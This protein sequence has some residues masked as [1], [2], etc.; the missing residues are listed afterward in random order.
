M[1]VNYE[2]ALAALR[3]RHGDK[4][5]AHSVGTAQA[6]EQL[7]LIYGVD[8]ADARLAGLLHDWDRELDGAAVTKAAEVSGV[9][10]GDAERVSPKLL[11]ART[12]ARAVLEAFPELPA[13]V[14]SAIEKHTLA[15]L[16][17]SPLDQVVYIADMMEPGRQYKGVDA[18]REAA[19]TVSLDELFALAYQQSMLHVVRS[20]KHMHPESVA[21]WNAAVARRHG[22]S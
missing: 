22:E 18:L 20:R 5:Y 21:V 3:A 12:G 15:A 7:A 6:A 1:S 10:I 16:D 13:Q 2:E 17:M 11:H 4:A 19:G 8:A 14:Y 9:R